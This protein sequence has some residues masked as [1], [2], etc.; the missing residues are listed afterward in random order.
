M[1]LRS[2]CSSDLRCEFFDR[3]LIAVA[4]QDTSIESLACFKFH[5]IGELSRRVSF[6]RNAGMCLLHIFSDAFRQRIYPG[7]VQE[8]DPRIS[9]NLKRFDRRILKSDGYQF[10]VEE[11]ASKIGGKK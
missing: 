8:R 3:K 1:D 4:F 7:K 5:K 6:D 9:P 2:L 10:S 11:L